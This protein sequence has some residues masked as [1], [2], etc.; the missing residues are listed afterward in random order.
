MIALSCCLRNNRLME[1]RTGVFIILLTRGV[2]D[3]L[4]EKSAC[5]I[6]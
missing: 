2:L 1:V 4:R 6:Y 3:G 5:T